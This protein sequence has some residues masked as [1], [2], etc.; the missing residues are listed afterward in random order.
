[1][2]IVPAFLL[3]RLYVKQSLRNSPQGF[4]F[5]LNNTLGSGFGTE[6]FPLVLDGKELPKDG[7]YFIRDGDEVPFAAVSK[8]RPFTLPVNKKIT[9]LVRGVTL[10]EGPHKINFS[11]V[12]QGLGK[13]GFDF[14][15]MVAKT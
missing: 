7:S 15:D 14:T 10:A 2:V 3:R 5:E 6:L 9:I 8:E 13:L 4:Q 1:M 11:F 12:A